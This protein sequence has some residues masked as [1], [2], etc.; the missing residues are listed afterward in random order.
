[1]KPIK[2]ITTFSNNGYS[3]YGRKWIETFTQQVKDSNVTADIYTEFPLPEHAGINRINFDEAIPQHRQWVVNYEHNYNRSTTYAKKMGVRFSFKS[4]VMMH[5]LENNKDCYVI[6]LDGDCIFKHQ[7]FTTFPESLLNGNAI[8]CQREHNG[9]NDH[10]ESGIVIFDV[11]HPDTKTFLNNFKSNYEIPQITSM[12]SPFD[13]FIIFKSLNNLP[14]TDLNAEHGK[15]GI[16]SDPN[17][18]FLHPEINKRFLH[19]IGPTGKNS[20][21]NWEHISLHDEYFRLLKG[22]LPMSKEQKENVKNKL[23]DLKKRRLS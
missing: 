16:Q 21:D 7:D 17:L 8:A 20:Y 5:A 14:Y 15:G 4:F 3:L 18:T 19:N 11:D 13:G 9:G 1:M 23:L 12:D 2:F 10:I 6:W 22:K